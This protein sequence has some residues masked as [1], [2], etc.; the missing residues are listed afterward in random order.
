MRHRLVPSVVMGIGLLVTMRTS[1][2]ASGDLASVLSSAVAG[3]E[4]IFTLLEDLSAGADFD[5]DAGA[6][7]RAVK[8][9]GAPASST[10]AK[11][12]AGVTRFSKTGNQI[13][14]ERAKPITVPFVAGGVT[15]GW[16]EFDSHV[17]F[18]L[19]TDGAQTQLG[20]PS[21]L[22]VAETSD[23]FHD[24]RSLTYKAG[25]SPTVS[26]TAGSFI[27]SGT[28]T[29]TLDPRLPPP[30]PMPATAPS[31]APVPPSTEATTEPVETGGLVSKLDH[32]P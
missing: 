4:P 6:V 1:Q 27:F 22:S 9:S 14:L 13:V 7:A 16:L 10:I 8:A 23:S 15:K 31:P 17:T 26:I 3:P 12:L 20:D 2:A 30:P 5:A 11:L 24:L 25:P 29:F 28:R 18:T 21:G 32:D 19:K